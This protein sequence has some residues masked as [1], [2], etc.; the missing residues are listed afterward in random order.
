MRIGKATATLCQ[1]NK[2]GRLSMLR[3]EQ[4]SAATRAPTPGCFF[5]TGRIAVWTG[6]KSAKTKQIHL[7]DDNYNSLPEIVFVFTTERLSLSPGSH[8]PRRIYVTEPRIAS[9][10]GAYCTLQAF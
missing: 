8:S 1:W 9:I 7:I 5:L 3:I 6:A 4:L 10:R 2:G